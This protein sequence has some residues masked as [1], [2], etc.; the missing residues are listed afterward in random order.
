MLLYEVRSSHYLAGRLSAEP[1]RWCITAGGYG[2][3]SARS[4]AIT[5]LLAA[6]SS[7]VARSRD[8]VPAAEASYAASAA[9]AAA[10]TV[11][12]CSSTCVATQ[13]STCS[14]R[15]LLSKCY[16]AEA[17]CWHVVCLHA[18]EID[19]SVRPYHSSTR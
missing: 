2:A 9:A 19:S 12:S 8:A 5:R 14:W 16:Q 7:A 10:G 18:N 13:T 15:R 17:A 11:Y 3:L 4:L 1:A 6:S